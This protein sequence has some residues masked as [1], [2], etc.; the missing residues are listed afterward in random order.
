[1]GLTFTFRAS[2]LKEVPFWNST[3][4]RT[5]LTVILSVKT[6]GEQRQTRKARDGVTNV[7]WGAQPKSTK[8]TGG[9]RLSC[10][11]EFPYCT[12]S[13]VCQ[14]GLQCDQM[15][16]LFTD[17]DREIIACTGCP[18]LVEYRERIAREK[19]RAYLD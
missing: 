16:A 12:R 18:R 19:R 7:T 4:S 1:V 5:A 2:T 3:K 13:L 17:L 15:S 6:G 8:V 9:R 14:F 10:I 11:R